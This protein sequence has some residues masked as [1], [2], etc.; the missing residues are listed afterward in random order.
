M[1][2]ASPLVEDGAGTEKPPEQGAL[3]TQEP[4]GS[5]GSCVSILLAAAPEAAKPLR[6]LHVRAF[7]ETGASCSSWEQGQ[8]RF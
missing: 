4:D 7:P 5:Y 2:A 3:R 1:H 8:K 6:S